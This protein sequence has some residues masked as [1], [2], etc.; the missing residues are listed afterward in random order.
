MLKVYGSLIDTETRCRHYF[1]EED[2]I[3]IK[4]KCCNK[5]YPCYKCHNEFEKHAIKR[6][7]E[8]SFNEK[9]ILCGVCK[10]ELTINEYM[11]VERCPNCQSRFNN[12]CKYHYHIYFEI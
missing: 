11:M 2:I 5:Y 3:A 1:T 4:F 6:W 9:A 10:H 8:P 12:R 7:S